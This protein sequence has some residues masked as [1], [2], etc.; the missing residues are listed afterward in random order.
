MKRL[1]EVR[2]SAPRL[3]VGVGVIVDVLADQI[4]QDREEVRHRLT[5][6][7][8]TAL[9]TADRD[10]LLGRGARLLHQLPESPTT[11]MRR[12]PQ[13]KSRG[14][15]CLHIVSAEHQRTAPHGCLDLGLVARTALAL[16]STH[17]RNDIRGGS[18]SPLPQTPT[19]RPTGARLFY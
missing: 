14:D 7:G 11:Q 1:P 3:L 13:P 18:S 6:A 19:Q 4:A 8:F 15:R 9:D 5:S 2:G 17:V 16:P 10:A 12:P